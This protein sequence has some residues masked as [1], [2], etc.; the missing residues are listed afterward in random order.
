MATIKKL[1]QDGQD[2]PDSRKRPAKRDT[3]PQLTADPADFEDD[4]EVGPEGGYGGSGPD[5]SRQRQ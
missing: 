2:Q 5:Q 4:D 1:R 3:E